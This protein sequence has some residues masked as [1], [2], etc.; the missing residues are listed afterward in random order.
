MALTTAA[1]DI[2]PKVADGCLADKSDMISARLPTLT[3]LA[4]EEPENSFAPFYLSLIISQV[5]RVCCSARAQAVLVSHSASIL[6]RI[7]PASIRNRPAE[8]PPGPGLSAGN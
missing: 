2:E 3:R 7:D 6:N 4:I 5:L 8:S 1:L